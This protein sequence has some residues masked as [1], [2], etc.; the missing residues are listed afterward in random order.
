M[1]ATE[2]T[3]LRRHEAAGAGALAAEAGQT[4]AMWGKYGMILEEYGNVWKRYGM[5]LAPEGSGNTKK[6][7]KSME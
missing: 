3:H 5:T 7:W 2:L 6:V 1:S 4:P